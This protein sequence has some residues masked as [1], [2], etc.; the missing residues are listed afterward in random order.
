MSTQAQNLVHHFIGSQLKDH[1]VPIEDATTFDELGLD[2]LDLVLVVLR[3]EDVTGANGD[4][5]INALEHSTKAGDLV[6]LVDRWW[7]EQEVAS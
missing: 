6:A 2:A 3:L 5:F 7:Q 1:H 4:F